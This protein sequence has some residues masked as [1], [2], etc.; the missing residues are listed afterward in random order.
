M[1]DFDVV[2][3][4]MLGLSLS[5]SAAQIGVWLLRA[6]PRAVLNAGRLS[7]VGLSIL[8]PLILLWLAASGRSTLAM[9]LVAFVLPVAIE[10]ARRWHGWLAPLD[11]LRKRWLPRRPLVGDPFH[12]AGSGAIDSRLAEQCAALLKTYLEQTALQ[13]AQQPRGSQLANGVTNGSGN[14]T[15]H[16]RMSAEE[17]LQV[18][19]LGPSAGAHDVREAYSRLEERLDPRSGG[20]RYL[21]AT[22]SEARDV[23][24]GV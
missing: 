15:G 19:G 8:T 3:Y 22:I 17:A 7:A 4:A 20:T 16:T 18:L 23:L 21:A 6:N 11:A 14:G 9:M 24:L 13:L 1:V 12:S 10:G 2:A 5:I